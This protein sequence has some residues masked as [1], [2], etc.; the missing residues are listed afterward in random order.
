MPERI[1]S[2]LLSCLVI[3][4]GLAFTNV[5]KSVN[6]FSNELI[7]Q[8]CEAASLWET[9]LAELKKDLFSTPNDS[10][11]TLHFVHRQ[12][13]NSLFELAACADSLALEKVEGLSLEFA[14]DRVK[15]PRQ[16][17]MTIKIEDDAAGANA[18]C[19]FSYK[20]YQQDS[21]LPVSFGTLSN[22]PKDLVYDKIRAEAIR[23]P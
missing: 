22:N 8:G 5:T 10:K 3:C 23:R 7:G 1:K 12:N 13:T 4:S 6:T 21:P 20:Q 19:T 18:C 14:Y 9:A 2:Y 16:N 15:I 11:K 17:T